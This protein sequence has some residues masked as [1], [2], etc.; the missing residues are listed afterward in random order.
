MG[1]IYEAT[2]EPLGRRV[3]VKT[4]RDRRQHLTGT[5]QVRFLR[6]QR[7]LAQLHHTHIVPI[8]AAGHDGALQYFA[9][10]YIDGAALHH[11]VRTAR[12]HELSAHRNRGHTPTPTLAALAAEARSSMPNGDAHDRNGAPGSGQPPAGAEPT[13]ATLPNVEP[14]SHWARRQPQS[15]RRP[16]RKTAT[17]NSSYRPS[18]SARWPG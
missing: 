12:L 4:I 6:E 10:S 15:S 7:V 2:Q 14:R 13:T 11:V 3:A 5:L 8:H 17:A 16:C 1:T 9:M 18:I